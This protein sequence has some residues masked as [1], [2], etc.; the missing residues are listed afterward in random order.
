MIIINFVLVVLSAL[1]IGWQLR[2]LMDR[3]EQKEDLTQK[4]DHPGVPVEICCPKCGKHHIDEG[5]WATKPHHTHL[6]AGCGHE[7]RPF[8][9]PTVGV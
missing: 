6:C 5:E 2:G 3:R 7:W 4:N 1:L 8:E 9:Y